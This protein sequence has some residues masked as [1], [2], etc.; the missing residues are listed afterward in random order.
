MLI[1]ADQALGQTL[2]LLVTFLG[3]GVVVNVLIVYIVAQV[4][5]ERKQ[6]QEHQPGA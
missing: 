6:N 1:G 5:A 2:A 3:I 4:M